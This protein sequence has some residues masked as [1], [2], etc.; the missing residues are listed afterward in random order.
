MASKNTRNLSRLE[1]QAIPLLALPFVPFT[2]RKRLPR[3]AAIYFVLNA[4]GT[5]LYVGQSINL[6]LRWAAHHRAAKL[7]EHQ[8]TRIAWLVMD[9]ETLLNAVESACIAYFDPLCNGFRGQRT[10][11]RRAHLPGLERL[12]R[13]GDYKS[14]LFR[15]PIDLLTWLEEDALRHNRTVN[16]HMVYLI[17]WW[18]ER[19]KRDGPVKLTHSR[20]TP[21]ATPG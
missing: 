21:A 11:T 9:D 18:M 19:E 16:A 20:R 13:R 7:S 1:P 2:E 14:M 8:A 5:V 12:P 3:L 6:A 4:K 15:V 10:S 17:R